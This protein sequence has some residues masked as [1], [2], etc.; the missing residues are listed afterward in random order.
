MSTKN[1]AHKRLDGRTEIW[2]AAVGAQMTDKQTQCSYKVNWQ[3]KLQHQH[4]RI[5]TEWQMQ[6]WTRCKENE[7]FDWMRFKCVKCFVVALLWS[8]M[9]VGWL[10][11]GYK[12]QLYVCM[13]ICMVYIRYVLSGERIGDWKLKWYKYICMH[14]RVQ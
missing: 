10:S 11:A 5:C 12:R 2:N 8:W 3:M 6:R 13:Y 9:L 7:L 4:S 14:K 1:D